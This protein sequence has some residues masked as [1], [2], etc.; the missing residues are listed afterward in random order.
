M[1]TLAGASRTH[2]PRHARPLRLA[3]GPLRLRPAGHDCRAAPPV[4]TPLLAVT[5]QSWLSGV[6]PSCALRAPR[7]AASAE[8]A[9]PP[10]PPP[11]P[12]HCPRG[13]CVKSLQTRSARKHESLRPRQTPS[14]RDGSCGARAAP[15]Q[16][17][18][19]A[20]GF[21]EAQRLQ[22]G[23]P[24]LGSE[25][26][27]FSS[28]PARPLP[29]GPWEET[30]LPN[31]TELKGLDIP[32]PSELQ[33]GQPQHQL[34]PSLAEAVPSQWPAAKQACS[35]SRMLSNVIYS[36]DKVIQHLCYV[37][38]C[39]IAVNVACFEENIYFLRNEKAGSAHTALLDTKQGFED[40]TM[41]LSGLGEG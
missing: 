41:A 3:S 14:A 19:A 22:H 16:L 21:L 20:C 15:S 40:L 10:A 13:C 27:P 29:H 17:A 18:C 4:R 23:N 26:R 31:P 12:P 34:L 32:I 8:G 24:E 30:V 28:L 6:R 2:R 11:H 9:H 37:T 7:R 1:R 5:V 39:N 33:R 36:T 38:S 35:A 25:G